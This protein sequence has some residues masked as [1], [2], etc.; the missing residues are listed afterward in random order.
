MPYT[1]IPLSVYNSINVKNVNVTSV[2]G[3]EEQ[4]AL[5]PKKKKGSLE[6]NPNQ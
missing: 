6:V 2:M 1:D 3:R 4:L 5:L